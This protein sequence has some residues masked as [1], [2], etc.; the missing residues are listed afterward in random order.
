[1]AES[2]RLHT[3]RLVLLAW[4]LVIVV[5]VYLSYDYIRVRLDDNQL[6]T[7]LDYVVQEAGNANRPAKEVRALILVKAE[8]LNLPLNGNQILISGERQTLK[9]SLSYGVDIHMPGL[10][11]VIYHQAFAHE[12]S[13]HPLRWIF[14]PD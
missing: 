11:R 6:T 9:V 10:Q 13:Y 2:P 1:M 14:P 5:Y 4:I 12:A 7:Y 3:R 8:E